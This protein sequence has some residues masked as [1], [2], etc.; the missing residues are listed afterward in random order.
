VS[1]ALTLARQP[2]KLLTQIV[3]IPRFLLGE[4]RRY[5]VNVSTVDTDDPPDLLH[6]PFGVSRAT[7]P[8]AELLPE[9]APQK[10]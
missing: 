4:R 9:R 6:R 5:G 1:T 7:D 2:P 10:P 3:G 8:I